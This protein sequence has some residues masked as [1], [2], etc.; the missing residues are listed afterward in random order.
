M[1][2]HFYAGKT[3]YNDA[4]WH[5]YCGMTSC[6]P[7]TPGHIH[8]I[9]GQTSYDDGHVHRYCIATGPAIYVG[10]HH[11]HMYCGLTEA[12]EGHVHCMDNATWVYN[13]IYYKKCP[14]CT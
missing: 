14:P 5:N 2:S 10:G 11:Y 9:T 7:S 4:H 6:D 12:S 3:S 13:D 1:H 8:Y